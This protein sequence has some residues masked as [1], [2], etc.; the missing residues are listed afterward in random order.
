MRGY[1][2]LAVWLVIG[3]AVLGLAFWRGKGVPR[4]AVAVLAYSALVALGWP[5]FL[6]L[7]AGDWVGGLV[8]ARQLERA[9]KELA[10]L[11]ARLT[12]EEKREW[13]KD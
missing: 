3:I 13:T 12:E 10:A 4:G 1:A 7:M 11:D 5:V 2:V 9:E 8:Q 6:S